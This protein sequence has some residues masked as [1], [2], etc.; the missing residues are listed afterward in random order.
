MLEILFVLFM[1]QVIVGLL[2]SI[3]YVAHT[4][5]SNDAEIF[6]LQDAKDISPESSRIKL[7]T[8]K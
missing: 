5:Y 7:S 3:A 6:I 4:D 8:E 1:L 2:V